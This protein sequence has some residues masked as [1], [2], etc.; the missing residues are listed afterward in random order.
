MDAHPDHRIEYTDRLD[1]A[2]INKI[3]RFRLTRGWGMGSGIHKLRARV[4]DKVGAI[5]KSVV[6]VASGR[7]GS[8]MNSFIASANGCR[9][10]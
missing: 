5:I 4:R 10:P 1:V 2:R 7:K 6:E 3:P 8:L 9:I